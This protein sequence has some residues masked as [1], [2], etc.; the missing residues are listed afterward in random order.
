MEIARIKIENEIM[1]E[2]CNSLFS[3]NEEVKKSSSKTILPIQPETV[4]VFLDEYQK[5]LDFT[6][7]RTTPYIS[8]ISDNASN[9]LQIYIKQCD[10]DT[11]EVTVSD[12]EL[13]TRYFHKY[14]DAQYNFIN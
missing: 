1:I 4:D 3:K 7:G 12:I 9:E 2:I 10:A 5:Q 13:K 8:L 6:L 14:D 11:K